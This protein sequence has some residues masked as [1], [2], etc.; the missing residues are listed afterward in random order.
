MAR[1]K[2]KRTEG[3]RDL[4]N[5]PIGRPLRY[6]AI[7]NPDRH[8]DLMFGVIPPI[9]RF[10]NY[11]DA[12]V[13]VTPQAAQ[14][15]DDVCMGTAFRWDDNTSRV[16]EVRP[17]TGTQPMSANADFARALVA[18]LEPTEAQLAE[19]RDA[20]RRLEH[21]PADADTWAE[22]IGEAFGSYTD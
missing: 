5:A 6:Q 19:C 15:S 11:I 21:A 3:G 1:R 17:L 10:Q 8:R 9:G 7:P 4:V 18:G 2:I 22:R 20:L 12:D 16:T 14:A 13:V